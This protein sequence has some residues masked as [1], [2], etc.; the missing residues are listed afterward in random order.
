MYYRLWH[1]CTLIGKT[2]IAAET[3]T[4]P[5]GESPMKVGMA[6]RDELDESRRNWQGTGARD[7]MLSRRDCVKSPLRVDD[8]IEGTSHQ[9]D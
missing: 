6:F 9:E 5:D 8:R 7:D 4:F 3:S 2:L 1:F